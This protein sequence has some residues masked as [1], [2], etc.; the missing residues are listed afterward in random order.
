MTQRPRPH[1]AV[2]GGGL[3]GLTVA[4]ALAEAGHVLTVFD[5][6]RGPGGRLAT[7]RAE[8]LTFDH[9]A[10]YF[11]ADDPA[12]QVEV[13]RWCA[14]GVVARWEGR[15]AVLDGSTDGAGPHR[16]RDLAP[17]GARA[18]RFVG[19]PGMSALARQLAAELT[20]HGTNVAGPGGA[21]AEVR[22]GIR[23]VSVLADGDRWRLIDDSHADLGSF[24]AVLVTTP[25][26][27]A[28][29]LVAASGALAAV[30]RAVDMDP[31]WAVMLA[32]DT[33]LD[34]P[35]DGAFVNGGPLSWVARDSSKPGRPAGDRWVLHMGPRWSRVH[36]EDSPEA[37]VEAARG[38]LAEALGEPRLPVHVHAT[39]HRWRFA[40][41]APPREDVALF[42][43]ALGLGL[44]GDWLAGSKV[45]GAW[46][47][48]RALAARFRAERD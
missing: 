15:L 8:A 46:R 42:D 18:E 4:G 13:A 2:V 3:A 19:V 37:V 17:S 21:A 40:A 43:P 25:P 30:A 27:Q 47:S 26:S 10:Q 41:A 23:V 31:C 39:A 12:F 1:V 38:A 35:F 20:R 24:D 22:V 33:P 7:R 48:G 36:V 34:V 45:Q 44:A 14:A 9:G 6:G 16:L 11:T 5:K 32:F 28:E 29:P